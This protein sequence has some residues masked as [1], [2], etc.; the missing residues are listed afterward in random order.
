MT[1]ETILS[2]CVI[3]SGIALIASATFGWPGQGILASCFGTFIGLRI[4]VYLLGRFEYN[5]AE[6]K[7][8]GFSRGMMK[9]VAN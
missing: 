3:L 1:K 7:A 4:G 5:Y 8:H 9:N 2:L 6:R